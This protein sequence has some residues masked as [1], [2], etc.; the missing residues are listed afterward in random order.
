MDSLKIRT[1]PYTHHPASQ[2]EHEQDPGCPQ[3]WVNHSFASLYGC[4]SHRCSPGNMLLVF[5][6]FKTW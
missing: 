1:P 6:Y 5:T 3:L 2:I 4:N